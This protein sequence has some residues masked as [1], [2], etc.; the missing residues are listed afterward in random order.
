MHQRTP[1]MSRFLLLTTL[2]L[3]G[4]GS[5]FEVHA[6]K[7]QQRM[8]DRYGEVFDYPKVAAIYEDLEASG[9]ADVSVMRRLALAYR[10]MDQP[11]KAEGVYTRLMATGGAQPDDMLAYAD[12]LRANGKYKEALDW[13]GNYDAMT[14]GNARVQSYLK[15]PGVFDRLMRDSTRSSIRTVPINSPQADLGMSVLNE[16]LLFSSARG[17]GAGGSRT[18]AWDEEPYLNLYSALLKGTTAEEPLVMRNDINSRYHDGTV[19][20]DSLAKRMYYTRNQYYY[21]VLNKSQRGELN[22]GIYFCDVV[23]GEFGQQEWGNLVPFDHNDVDQN[24]GHPFVSPD[25]RRLYFTSDRPGGEGGTDIWF[26]D[27]LGNQWGAPQNMGPKVNTAGDEMYPMITADSV[28]HFASDGHPGLGGLDLFRTRLKKDGPGYVFNLG[29][30][31]NTRW[32][33]HSLILLNDSVGFLASDRSGG[34]GS[35]DIYGCTISPPMMYLAGTVIDKETKQPIEGAVI[36]LKDGDGNFVK[37]YDVKSEPGGRFMIDTEYHDKY[38]VIA[39]QAGYLQGEMAVV[40]DVDPLENIVIELMKYDYAA[41]GLVLNGETG[42]PIAGALVTLTDADGNVLGTVTTDATG[43][44]SFPLKPDTDYRVKVERDGFFKQSLRITTKGKANG[45]IRND[46]RLFPLALNTVVRLENILYD[47]AKW[48]IRPDAA[49]ELDKLVETLREN[50][51]V[52]IEL[53][54]H[55]DCRGKDAYNL[56]LSEKRAKSAVD[57]IISKGIGKDR[58]VSKGY[59]EIKPSETCACTTCTEE[60]HQRNRRTEFKVLGL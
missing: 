28:F 4:A 49:L 51:T 5:S 48:N 55:T 7:L 42:Q 13:Y 14:P 35:D 9:K 50:P 11:M 15:Q 16:L 17:E 1:P 19:S 24:N 56:S 6:Q 39:N 33:D 52:R 22:L 58:V 41:E 57:Y 3:A 21:G 34:M 31:V 29:Y 26:C 44:Y 12:L 46:F 20:Y 30:P 37:K 54:S 40:T 47:Y 38:V 25:G 59:G 18:Y 53:S 36:T 2:L 60:Q 43:G 27:N 10:K 8:A 23:L 45:I 32:N